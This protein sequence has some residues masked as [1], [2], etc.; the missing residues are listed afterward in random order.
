M[1][2]KNV[3]NTEAMY[4]QWWKP[5]KEQPKK[6]FYAP[7]ATTGQPAHERMASTLK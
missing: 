7:S 6:A 3:K 5:L 1:Q 2:E 4:I